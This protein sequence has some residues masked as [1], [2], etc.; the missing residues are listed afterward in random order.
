MKN[1]ILK[2]ILWPS[3]IMMF[4]DDEEDNEGLI[5]AILFQA[6]LLMWLMIIILR[7]CIVLDFYPF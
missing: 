2:V 7:L 3:S 1:K 5:M 6:N 4:W